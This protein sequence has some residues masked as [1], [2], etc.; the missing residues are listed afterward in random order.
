M[1]L[2]SLN[3]N[4]SRSLAVCQVVR[5]AS[6]ARRI[7]AHWQA[8]SSNERCRGGIND[9]VGKFAILGLVESG[10]AQS[11]RGLPHLSHKKAVYVHVLWERSPLFGFPNR[12]I[13][14]AP[15]SGFQATTVVADLDQ[16][17]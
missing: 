9:S 8:V 14:A 17:C 3:S 15:T 13:N 11:A 10:N 16:D 6:G 5:G 4:S 7:F 12:V 1:E 2:N